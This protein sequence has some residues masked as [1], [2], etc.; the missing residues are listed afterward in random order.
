MNNNTEA[1]WKENPM[2]GPNMLINL[3]TSQQQQKETVREQSITDSLKKKKS[4][5]QG[6]PNTVVTRN[7]LSQLTGLATGEQ[8]PN[9]GHSCPF[10]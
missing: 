8:Q 2:Q 10:P 9:V 6:S 3:L 4:W 1:T 5:L 7:A